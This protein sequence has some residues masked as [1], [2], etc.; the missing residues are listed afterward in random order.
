MFDLVLKRVRVVY[1]A[2]HPDDECFRGGTLAMLARLGEEIYVVYMTD[3]SMGS[4]KPEERGKKLAEKRKREALEGLKVLGISSDRAIFFDYPDGKLNKFKMEA[5][6]RLS[7][8]LSEIKPDLVIYPSTLD[9][10]PDHES[11]GEIAKSSIIKAELNVTE[12]SYLIHM[13]RIHRNLISS[14]K[15]ILK[16]IRLVTISRNRIIT[17]N[18]TEYKEIRLEAVKKH[19]SQYRYFLEL[20]INK[21]LLRFFN[22]DYEIFFVEKISDIKILQL[23]LKLNK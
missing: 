1:I 7:K 11:S 14:M 12:L 19:E 8:L 2:P 20:P 15:N 13:P 16:Y 21:D 22:E 18:I 9:A 10:H 3:G 23:I 4:P 5:T 17:V 6:D